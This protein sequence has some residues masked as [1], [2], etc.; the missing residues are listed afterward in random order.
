MATAI[1]LWGGCIM[2]IIENLNKVLLV[3]WFT[4]YARC[5]SC[6]MQIIL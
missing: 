1:T 6:Y 5:F 2:K 4:L 3:W